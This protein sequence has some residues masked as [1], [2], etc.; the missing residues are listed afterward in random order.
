LQLHGAG[1]AIAFP[2][3]GSVPISRWTSIELAVE[4]G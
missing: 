4:S 2:T 1:A 3:C